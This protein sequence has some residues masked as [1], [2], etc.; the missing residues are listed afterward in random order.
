[1]VEQ[2]RAGHRAER[3]GHVVQ[4]P[5]QRVGVSQPGT[6][7][8]LRHGAPAGGCEAG[9]EQASGEGEE[10]QHG[11]RWQE[12]RDEFEGAESIQITGQ[13]G[14]EWGWRGV[15][16]VEVENECCENDEVTE[17]RRCAR[18]PRCAERAVVP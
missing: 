8:E 16:V 9:A 10:D 15:Q 17:V 11:E 13:R 18:Q 1:V 5:E 4:H 12:H 14:A 2:Q 3:Q 6:F 7:D